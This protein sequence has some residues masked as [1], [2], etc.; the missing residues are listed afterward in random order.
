[1]AGLLS[2]FRTL[3][4]LDWVLIE[5]E[6]VV[7]VVVVVFLVTGAFLILANFLERLTGGGGSAGIFCLNVLVH[8]V[9][10]IDSK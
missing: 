10:S 2:A 6:V 9:V 5:L 8:D 7:V 3:E 1:M 4:M